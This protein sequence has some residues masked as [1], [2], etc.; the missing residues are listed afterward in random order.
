MRTP[1]IDV[2]PLR[3]I[4]GVAHFNEVFLTDVRVPGGERRGGGQR[5]MGGGPHHPGQRAHP[6]RWRP[7]GVTFA[8]LAALARATGRAGD[9]VVRQDLS[10]SYIRSEVLRYLGLRVRTALS[11]GQMPGPESSVMK[12][13]DVPAL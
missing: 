3:Q 7:S 4:T 11:R 5:G 13:G 2:R 12:L 1:G 10:R 8:D 6:D 9:P